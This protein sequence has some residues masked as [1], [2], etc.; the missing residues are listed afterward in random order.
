[1]RE[2][3]GSRLQRA[4]EKRGSAV[5]VGLDPEVKLFPRA[6]TEP[7]KTLQGAEWFG[8][9]AEIVLDFGCRII[10][11]VADLVPAIK[12]QAAFYERL[13]PAGI[14]ALHRTIEHARRQGLIVILDAKRNDIESTATAYA[15]AYL[16][17]ADATLPDGCPFDVDALTVNPYLGS[18][19]VLPFVQA[20]VARSKGI[21]VLVKTS[22]P[23]ASDFQDLVVARPSGSKEP[24]CHAVARK[25]NEWGGESV[26]SN[27]Y[28]AVGAVVGA[29]YPSEAL[30]L[31]QLMPRAFFLVPG[32]G[33]QGGDIAQLHV[34]FDRRGSGALI[35]ASRS[36]IYAHRRV[37]ERENAFQEI[38]R[39]ATMEL[40][41]AVERARGFASEANE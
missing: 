4:V 10:D 9:A 28:S 3:F 29:T 25:V 20:A 41:A 30:V 22:N 19:G 16:G 33:A 14:G 21:F 18:D 23:S 6:L 40:S 26:D 36:L 31:R 1:M 13:G 27:Q 24:L 7:L 2:G 15:D 37:P 32:V 35:A 8:R 39:E 5:V 34:F 11:A 38:A 17:K 12:P